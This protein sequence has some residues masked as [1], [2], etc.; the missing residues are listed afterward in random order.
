MNDIKGSI[1]RKWD[2]HFH[3]P[4]SYDYKDKSITNNQIINIL[5]KT[6]ISAVAITD[7]NII[8]VKRIKNLKDIAG[9]DI[10]IFPGIE[11]MLLLRGQ[12]IYLNAHGSQLNACDFLVHIFRYGVNFVFQFLRMTHHV[13]GAQGLV[14][15]AHVHDGGRVPLCRGQI[16]QPAFA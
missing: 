1:Y 12:G 9:D 13:G 10:T 8:D 2:L 3:T 11:V 15:K 6:N 7:H 5:K 14:G 4:S 16:N